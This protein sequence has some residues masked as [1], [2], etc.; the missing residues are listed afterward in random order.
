MQAY[1][2]ARL[3]L[4]VVAGLLAGAGAGSAAAHPTPQTDLAGIVQQFVAAFNAGDTATL[5]MLLDPA[6]QD[7]IT[8]WPPA[9]PPQLTAPSGRDAALQQ[10]SRRLVQAAAAN[11][12]ISGADRVQCDIT[13]SGGPAAAL[14]HPYT[15]TA[16]FTI[17]N[18]KIVRDEERLS[19]TTRDDFAALFAHQQPG[20]PTTG[21]PD[22]ATGSG[23]LFF[24]LAS[25]GLLAAVGGVV[26]RRRGAARY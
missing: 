19:D 24:L 12:G 25:G 9:A 20:M 11:C 1:V 6:Y 26:L 23:L 10:A 14:A 18:G 17:A 7:V 15:E 5:R 3:A 22:G 8:N 13:L 4:V 21:A 16:V 2:K